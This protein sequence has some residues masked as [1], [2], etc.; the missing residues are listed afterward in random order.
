MSWTTCWWFSVLVWVKRSKLM[1]SRF[2]DSR[3]S[4][5]YRSTT[6]A[7]R[8]AFLVG[9]YGDGGAVGVAAGHHQDLVSP[10]PVIAGKN[11]RGQ[12]TARHM[13]Q[14]QRPVGVGPCNSYE[15]PF[16]QSTPPT[17]TRNSSRS[18]NI[19]RLVPRSNQNSRIAQFL[20]SSKKPAS[21]K[22]EVP[23][24]CGLHH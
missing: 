15:N 11:V 7:G 17:S 20:L 2:Q 22:L 12:V 8:D 10:H 6:S 5:W 1:P 19:F 23:N 18:V 24:P 9:P 3:N 13:A 14:V 16:T 4:A 21:R